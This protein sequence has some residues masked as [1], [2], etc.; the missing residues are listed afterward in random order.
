MNEQLAVELASFAEKIALAK[1]EEAKAAER[2]RE[3]EYEEQRFRLQWL[4][5]SIK[6]QQKKGTV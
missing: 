3:L 6:N 2:V 4:I 5:E 1:L